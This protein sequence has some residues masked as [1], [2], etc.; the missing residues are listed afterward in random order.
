MCLFGNEARKLPLSPSIPFVHNP[1]YET[2]PTE[3]GLQPA[4]YFRTL[5]FYECQIRPLEKNKV[6]DR[7]A[8]TDFSSFI[9]FMLF[10][11]FYADYRSWWKR[12]HSL[13]H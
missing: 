11:I 2:G 5:P 1:V 8:R 13:I 6:F 7:S 12:L 10:F 3:S 9:D 4:T